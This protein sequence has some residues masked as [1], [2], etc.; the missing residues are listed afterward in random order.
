MEKTH[1]QPVLLEGTMDLIIIIIIIII[2]GIAIVRRN[3]ARIVT[4]WSVSVKGSG[5]LEGIRV[6]RRFGLK[7]VFTK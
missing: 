1:R 6:N 7:W 2:T 4:F 3:V 5:V